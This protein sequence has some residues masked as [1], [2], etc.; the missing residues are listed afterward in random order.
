MLTE[1]VNGDV[2]LWTRSAYA[3]LS[4]NRKEREKKNSK[5]AG[6]TGPQYLWVPEFN[7]RLVES[8]DAEPSG[9]EGGPIVLGHLV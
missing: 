6:S 4:L 3:I 9:T 7:L 5:W 1:L 2:H 8:T